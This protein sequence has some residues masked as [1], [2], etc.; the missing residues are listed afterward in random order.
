MKLHEVELYARDPEASK[1]FYH[2]LLGLPIGQDHE[3]LKVFGA[4]WPNLDLDA[5]RHYPGQVSI[6]FP[7]KDLDLFVADVRAKGVEVGEP[8]NAHLGMRAVALTDPDGHRVE[9]Q[10]PTDASPN[11]LKQ[12]VA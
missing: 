10:S 7:V 1:E 2:G 4:G 12:M 5:S 8:R 3:G 11:W 6:S 9:I